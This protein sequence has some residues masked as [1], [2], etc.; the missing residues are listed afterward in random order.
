[1]TVL[2]PDRRLQLPEALH[3]AFSEHVRL[4]GYLHAA[5]PTPPVQPVAKSFELLLAEIGLS[6]QLVQARPIAAQRLLS[7]QQ[8]AIGLH[9]PRSCLIHSAELTRN[10]VGP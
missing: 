6:N 8:F 4:P 9:L 10:F 5:E 3:R 7:K 2:L 1:M